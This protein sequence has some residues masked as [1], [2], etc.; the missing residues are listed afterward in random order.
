MGSVNGSCSSVHRLEHRPGGVE[1]RLAADAAAGR[2]FE[3]LLAENRQRF[4]RSLRG[5]DARLW[6]ALLAARRFT[7]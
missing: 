6:H 5:S 1:R 2:R 4:S 3:E 7:G